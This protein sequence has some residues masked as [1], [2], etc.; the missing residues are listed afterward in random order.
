MTQSEAKKQVQEY[1]SD[2]FTRFARISQYGYI[3]IFEDSHIVLVPPG[4]QD[5][6]QDAKCYIFHYSLYGP[7]GIKVNHYIQ[8]RD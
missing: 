7:G 2:N 5:I 6:E 3:A 1:L 4:Q 8:K